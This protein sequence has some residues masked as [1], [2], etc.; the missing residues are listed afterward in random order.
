MKVFFAYGNGTEWGET[1]QR[2]TVSVE[3]FVYIK[4]PLWKYTSSAVEHEAV[5][6]IGV[7]ACKVKSVNFENI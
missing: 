7:D 3:Y 5:E 6:A 2:G 4:I 1:P